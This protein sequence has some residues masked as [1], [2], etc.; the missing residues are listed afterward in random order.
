L[1]AILILSIDIGPNLQSFAATSDDGFAG[2]NAGEAGS[3]K[4]AFLSGNNRASPWDSPFPDD[5]GLLWEGDEVESAE[6]C[7]R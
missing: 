2:G 5:D 3:F 1:L 6:L 4:A 7:R